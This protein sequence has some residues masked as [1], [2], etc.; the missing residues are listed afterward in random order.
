MS[1]APAQRESV[2]AAG[3][4][5]AGSPSG[6]V[7]LAPMRRLAPWRW[8]SY[9]AGDWALIVGAF[10]AAAWLST[11][12]AYL[13]ALLLVG[14]RQHALVILGHEGAHRLVTRRRHLNDALTQVLCFWP[15]GIDVAS[16]REFHFAHHRNLNTPDDP[17]MAYR[18]MGAPGWDVPR[19]RWQVALR[20]AADLVG[21]GALE[22]FRIFRFARPH[23]WRGASGPVVLHGAVIGA[24]VVA[25]AWWIPVL[26]WS[27]GLTSFSAVWRF[28]CW[29]EHLGTED[30][31]RLHLTAVERFLFA[32]HNISYHWEH[33]HCSGIPFWNL[34][35]LRRETPG[36]P[37]IRLWELFRYYERCAK[38]ASG[39]PTLDAEERQ[40][41][42]RRSPA[43]ELGG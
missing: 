34:P 7:D 40:A 41:L 32:P 23:G 38:I 10:A 9:V 29:L 1:Q 35:R 30:T 6:G 13:A 4:P 2:G 18:E 36:V 15:V 31:H 27:A 37:V 5:R 26:W 12:W 39:T 21:L 24:S 20:F 19:P 11:W 28:R 17:E 8:G 43:R 42:D 33:H 25:G 22:V 16:Y 3:L 14:N